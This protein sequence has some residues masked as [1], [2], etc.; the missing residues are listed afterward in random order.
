MTVALFSTQA[1]FS[2]H[3]ENDTTDYTIPDAPP[4]TPPKSIHLVSIRFSGGVP[5]P[6][7]SGLFRHTF[8]GIYEANLSANIRIGNF[9]YAGLG[10]RNALLSVSNRNKFG[11]HTKLSLNCAYVRAGYDK[12]HSGRV[13]SSFYMLA[14]YA[15]GL[16]TGV[17]DYDHIDE[18]RHLGFAFIQPTYGINF[19]GDEA[20]R[21]RVGFYGGYNM[22][23]WQYDPDQIDQ[24]YIDAN[25]KNYGNKF[26]ASWW[27]IGVELYVGIGK[28]K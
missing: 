1:L 15:Q 27:I 10:Y 17:T 11:S 2:Q 5:N 12:Y 20:E 14:G 25:M 28:T 21:F 6:L 26:N 7:T 19:F 9:M 3:G 8:I 24:S 16:Y 4:S 18:S 22:M 13:F 23:L